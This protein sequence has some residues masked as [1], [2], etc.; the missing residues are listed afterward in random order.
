MKNIDL[1]KAM[2]DIDDQYIEEA[3]PSAFQEKKKSFHFNLFLK[4]ACAFVVGIS[5]YGIYR[6]VNQNKSISSYDEE[7]T[8]TNPYVDY[9]TL[10]DA[11]NAIGFTIV[12][13]ED[14]TTK[15]Y[16]VIE[17]KILQVSYY[18][19]QEERY[20]SIRKA[21]G[22]EDISGDYTEYPNTKVVGINDT[23]VTFKEDDENI[24]VTWMKDGYS[25]AISTSEEE[26]AVLEFVQFIIENN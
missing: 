17:S 26:S 14:I 15:E 5:S 25:Y 12:L 22:N 11:S 8:I 18:D 4:L 10:E 9:S 1:L 21:V 24:S 20:L 2:N 3:M 13:P 6:Y 7:V 23:E 16:T 19:A